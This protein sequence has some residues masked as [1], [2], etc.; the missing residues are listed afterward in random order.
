LRSHQR[1]IAAWES[2]KFAEEV[3]PVRITQGLGKEV[4]VDRDEGPRA[5][6]TLEKLAKLRPVYKDGVCTAG[7]S[8]SENDGSSV[9]VL[10][11]EKKAKELRVKPMAYYSCCF[12]C[13]DG[14]N[15]YLSRGA[16]FRQ[17]SPAKVRPFNRKKSI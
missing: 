6:T 12:Y 7:N 1:A 2:G 16:L 8:S 15:P 4:I 9:V 5:D 17:K 3:V 10:A 11:S 14:S 13:C